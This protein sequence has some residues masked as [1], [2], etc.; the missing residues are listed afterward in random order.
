MT[1]GND[2]RVTILKREGNNPVPTHIS[3]PVA[4]R[5]LALLASAARLERLPTDEVRAFRVG[6]CAC[7]CMQGALLG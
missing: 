4:T 3:V 5:T 7:L 6:G 1:E 2:Q